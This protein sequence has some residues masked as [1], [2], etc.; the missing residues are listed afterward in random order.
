M[1]GP[2]VCGEAARQ[3][4]VL[5]LWTKQ[6]ALA[7]ETALIVLL[8]LSPWWGCSQKCTTNDAGCPM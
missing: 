8:K 5:S 2:R 3:K 7:V 1:G 4:I 6:P